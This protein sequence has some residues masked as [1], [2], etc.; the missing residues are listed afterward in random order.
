VL[1]QLPGDPATRQNITWGDGNIWFG[2]PRT[3]HKPLII[4]GDLQVEDP[5]GQTTRVGDGI[6]RSTTSP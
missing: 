3:D 5:S 2:W 6:L 4:C 1:D